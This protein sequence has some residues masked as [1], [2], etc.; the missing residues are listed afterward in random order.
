MFRMLG[1]GV[2]TLTL[3]MHEGPLS[4]NNHALIAW[5]GDLVRH[6]SII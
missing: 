6:N 3:V 4:Q 2:Q 1:C 5:T